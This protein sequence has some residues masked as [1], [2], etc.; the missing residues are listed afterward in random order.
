METMVQTAWATR[1]IRI[2]GMCI[3]QQ[4]YSQTVQIKK[5]YF[6]VEI[7]ENERGLSC[8]LCV[9]EITKGRRLGGFSCFTSSVEEAKKRAT[10][11]IDKK[12][13]EEK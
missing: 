8:S 10:K 2:H 4:I 12:I 7:T 5:R 11:Y 13:G 1:E 6:Y 3:G 9:K